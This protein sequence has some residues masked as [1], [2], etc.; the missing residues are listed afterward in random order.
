MNTARFFGD[1][2]IDPDR[3][4]IADDAA[5]GARIAAALGGCSTLLTANHGLATTGSTVAE[6]FER[7]WFFEKAA[8]TVLLALAS[9]RPLNVMSDRVAAQTAQGWK[10][11]AGMAD[12]HFAHLK[13]VLDRDDPDHRD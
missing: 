1:L 4:G 7:L 10:A 8:Q 9:V 5:E 2:A 11:C 13:S 6:A 12:V 3:G